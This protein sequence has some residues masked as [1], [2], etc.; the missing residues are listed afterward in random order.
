MAIPP[1]APSTCRS[2]S[3]SRAET[4]L[5]L[6]PCLRVLLWVFLAP[7]E[8]DLSSLW[9]GLS[10]A[11]EVK[12]MCGTTLVTAQNAAEEIEIELRAPR[13]IGRSQRFL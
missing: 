13:I 10:V 12:K 5:T 8:Q 2:V 11:E 7:L 6:G 4:Y 3:D 1:A 9:P